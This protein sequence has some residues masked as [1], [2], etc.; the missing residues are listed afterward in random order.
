MSALDEN[1]LVEIRLS[2]QKPVT[3]ESLGRGNDVLS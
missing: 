1:G 3:P 2:H